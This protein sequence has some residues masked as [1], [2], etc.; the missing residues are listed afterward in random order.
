MAP[1]YTVKEGDCIL[2]IADAHGFFWETIWND[3][4]NAELKNTRKD[5]NTLIPG[6]KV[7]IPDLRQKKHTCE[8]D[9]AF[10]FKKKG[11]PAKLRFQIFDGF[12]F[13]INEE[14]ILKVGK[15]SYTGSTDD[16]GVIEITV[17]T[18]VK[19]AT[20][21]I[22]PNQDEFPVQ[23]GALL[24]VDETKGIQSRLS[25][26]GFDCGEI[27]GEMHEQTKEALSD[28]QAQFN[29]KV[30][31]EL[32]EETKDKLVLLH[33]NKSNLAE[34]LKNDQPEDEEEDGDSDVNQ[35]D[36]ADSETQ[37]ESDDEDSAREEEDEN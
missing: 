11:I 22:G 6:D 37:Q 34:E 28:F 18:K 17:S 2:S 8:S 15:H 5:P 1:E 33:D 29:L 14:Y 20:L 30:T 24:P 16:E 26:L 23:I 13:R 25:N 35:D 10:T 12:R 31:G 27:N 4:K 19:E 9:K 21:Y 3:P 36:E 32:N 7:H